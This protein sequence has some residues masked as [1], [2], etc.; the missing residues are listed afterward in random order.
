[1]SYASPH[2]VVRHPLR[3]SAFTL[4]ELLV[5]IAI[6]AILAAILFPVFAQAREKARQTSCLSNIKQIGLGLM[7]YMQD[8]DG[9]YPPHLMLNVPSTTGG[10]T[11]ATWPQFVQPN[12]KN[13]GVFS[14]PSAGDGPTLNE[15]SFTSANYAAS[16]TAV[17]YGMNYWL[18]SYYYAD[19]N[20]SAIKSPAQTVWVLETGSPQARIPSGLVNP[21]AGFYQAYAPYYGAVIAR[22]NATYGFDV[23]QA[24]ARLANRHNDG[25]NVLWADGHAKWTKR[26]VL[27]ED[28]HGDGRT[29][30]PNLVPDNPGSKYWWGRN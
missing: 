25:L 30:G 20:E 28:V 12:I 15:L 17:T 21:A 9:T 2:P 29:I 19:A 10:I 3:T 27:E 13:R 16:Q 22:T 24:A 11:H 18:N 5:V 1:M 8:A 6:I 14:C 4:I 26:N 23:P 7:M